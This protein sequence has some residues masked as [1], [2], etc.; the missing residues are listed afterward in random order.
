MSVTFTLAEVRSMA[1]DL[2]CDPNLTTRLLNYVRDVYVEHDKNV[3]VTDTEFDKKHT[4]ELPEDT[5]E[6]VYQNYR[7]HYS[8]AHDLDPYI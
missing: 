1:H 8:R 4:V 3:L 5:I 6:A 2:V 7:T